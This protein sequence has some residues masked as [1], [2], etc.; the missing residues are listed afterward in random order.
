MQ[1]YSRRKC[2]INEL[3]HWTTGVLYAC[4]RQ[5]LMKLAPVNGVKV[6]QLVFVQE[7]DVVGTLCNFQTIRQVNCSKC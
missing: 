2:D 6:C 5:S 3:K 4:S 7:V 1:Q